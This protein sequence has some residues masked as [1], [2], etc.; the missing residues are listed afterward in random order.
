MVVPVA[1][2]KGDEIIARLDLRLAGS[3]VET[4]ISDGG[5]RQSLRGGMGFR[6]DSS[7]GFLLCR[8]GCT[9]GERGHEQHRRDAG[10]RLELKG[11]VSYVFYL[12]RIASDSRRDYRAG[13]GGQYCTNSRQSGLDSEAGPS[14]SVPTYRNP[15]MASFDSRPKAALTCSS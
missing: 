3:Q 13:A 10:N 9:G 12:A 5:L 7:H 15:T 1:G 6:N 14:T 11:E 8:L 2:G 4:E